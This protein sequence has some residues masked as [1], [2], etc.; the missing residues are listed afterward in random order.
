MYVES[1]LDLDIDDT[2]DPY[3]PNRACR[4][5]RPSSMYPMAISDFDEPE[6]PT[7]VFDRDDLEIPSIN[8][9]AARGSGLGELP[10]RCPPPSLPVTQLRVVGRAVPPPFRRPR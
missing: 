3:V 9:R 5:A 4:F 7:T 2:T 10:A 1:V 8:E 6:D